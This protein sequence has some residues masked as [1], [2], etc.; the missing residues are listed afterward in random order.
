[1][2]AKS[3]LFD[4]DLG[5]RARGCAHAHGNAGTLESG[6]GSRGG[7]QHALAVADDN[8]AVGAEVHQGYQRFTFVQAGGQDPRQ[9]VAADKPAEA[10]QEDNFRVPWQFPA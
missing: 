3:S 7:A 4:V 9:D 1:M 2:T 8:F 6:P 5:N 10:R